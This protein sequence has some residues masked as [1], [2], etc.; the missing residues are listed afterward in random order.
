MATVLHEADELLL[1]FCRALRAAGLPV[2][3]DRAQS[4][5]RAAAAVG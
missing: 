2:T 3:Q 5:L 1:G 4:Y